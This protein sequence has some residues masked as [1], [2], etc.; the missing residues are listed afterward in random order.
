MDV[1]TKALVKMTFGERSLR[2]DSFE[3]VE[4]EGSPA[5]FSPKPQALNPNP[6]L[7]LLTKEI[8]Y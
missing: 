5:S 6:Q 2:D 8:M 4:H 7:D 3:S 1:R